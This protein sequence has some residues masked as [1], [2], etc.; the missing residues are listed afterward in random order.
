MPPSTATQVETLR[1][2]VSTVY[3]VTVELAT[4]ARPGSS[5]SRLSSPISS[6]SAPT[7]A[8]TYCSASR[9]PLV[10][11]VGGTEPAAEVVDAE[12][13]ELRDR[14][15]R[16]PERLEL[17]QL[18]ADVEV[19][20]DQLERL[21]LPQAGDRG[22]RLGDREAELRVGLPGRDLVMG[23]AGDAGGDPD[24]HLLASVKLGRD[25]LEPLELVERVDHDVADACV[26]RRAQLGDGL[27]VAVQVGPPRV[28]ARAQ[29][30]RELSAGGNVA[31]QSLVG[32]RS[33]D[34]G[35]RERLGGEQHVEVAV[36]S[37]DR[38]DERARPRAQ[39]ILDDDV[40]RGPELPRQ[41]DGVTAAELEPP[42]LVDA[43]PEREQ[44]GE[45][46]GERRLHRDRKDMV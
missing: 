39:V 24:Q 31:R 13:P 46:C 26:E 14:P 23:V 27:G 8:S 5:S 45:R 29:R 4:S 20:P 10:G 15:D 42:A 18:R 44:M 32:E 38:V 2:T 34:G 28:K 11:R 16:L 21:A 22:R 9:R 40:R 41:L 35:A 36:A 37:G 12:L 1:L 33:V 6:C 3:R 17:E 43:R 30:E 7:I 25:L 19:Q